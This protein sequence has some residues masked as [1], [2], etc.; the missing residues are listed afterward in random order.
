MTGTRLICSGLEQIIENV[1]VFGAFFEEV[2]RLYPEAPKKL[3]FNEVLR[4]ILDRWV[5]DLIQYTQ[6]NVD[7]LAA[8][9][10]QSDRSDRRELTGG[11]APATPQSGL[12]RFALIPRGW[13]A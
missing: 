11:G 13:S 1:P 4:R 9:V 10:A 8:A 12:R 2:E 7:R 5:G 6:A 3:Q